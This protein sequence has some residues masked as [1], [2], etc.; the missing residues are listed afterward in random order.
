MLQ[1]QLGT[2]PSHHPTEDASVVWDEMT[3][4]YQ[5]LATV[6]FPTQ[7]SF[8]QERRVFWEERMS[9]SPWRGLSDHQPLGGINRLRKSVYTHSR[10]TRDSINIS[11]S[12][13]VSSIDELP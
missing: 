8:S 11:Q 3:A 5:T 10:K 6:T 12:Q 13:A 4:P 1:I 7:N 9:L 2:D